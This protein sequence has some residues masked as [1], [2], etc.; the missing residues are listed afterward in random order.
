MNG[1]CVCGVAKKRAESVAVTRWKRAPARGRG[2]RGAGGRASGDEVA[3]RKSAGRADRTDGYVHARDGE[4]VGDE[5][6]NGCEIDHQ[7]E[8]SS[9]GSPDSRLESCEGERRSMMCI[10]PR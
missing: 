9:G 2:S 1:G 6:S 8:F 10:V 4:V 5:V 3:R 7:E